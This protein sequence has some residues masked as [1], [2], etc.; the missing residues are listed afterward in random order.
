MNTGGKSKYATELLAK[1][2]GLKA[3]ISRG[4]TGNLLDQKE[5]TQ[6]LGQIMQLETDCRWLA[7]DREQQHERTGGQFISP[8]S[9]SFQIR[10]QQCNG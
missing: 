2:V 9:P 1:V 6:F 8:G 10:R 5:Y 3:Y 4:K 7:A